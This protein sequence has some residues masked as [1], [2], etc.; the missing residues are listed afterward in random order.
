[1]IIALALAAASVANTPHP[2]TV[3]SLDM[4][5]PVAPAP[6]EIGTEVQ[7][8]YELHLTSFAASPITLVELAVLDADTGEQL[9]KFNGEVLKTLLD[10]PDVGDLPPGALAPATRD[11]VYLSVPLHGKR[12]ARLT[13]RLM[14]DVP[15]EG[16]PHRVI[17]E[18]AIGIDS[19]SLPLIG[20]PLRR[21]TWA[22]I[23]DPSLKRGHR[24]VLY[25]VDGHAHLPGRFA[26]DWFGVD[27]S[28]R[29]HRNEGKRP[30]DYLGYGADVVAVADGTVVAS[31]DDV[32]DPDK[33]T[34]AV[35][36]P[37]GDATGNYITLDIGGGRYAFY[38][39]LRRG[40][41][42][43]VGDRVRRGQR[44]GAL[45]MTGQAVA[46]HLHFH[47]ADAAV[48]LAAE[49]RPYRLTGYTVLGGYRS[50]SDLGKK[51]WVVLPTALR[52][53]GTFPAA[54]TVI[55]FR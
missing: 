21:G 30:S 36:V 19:S 14:L 37:I 6:V 20:P 54:N 25:A 48:P 34:S 32:P 2:E 29:M 45:G 4:Q 27:R 3:Q 43:R 18:Q 1:M 35:R 33:I 50:I 12:P 15:V 7:L 41:A 39:H 49:G 17:L 40:L 55:S 42:V 44:L 11:V 46:P 5:I 26:V 38:E 53:D 24:R 16:A 51:P 31:R 47:I 9:A 22:A 10:R 13:H 28:G 8:L 52:A 23:Y